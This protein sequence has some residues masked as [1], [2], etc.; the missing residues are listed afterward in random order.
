MN[1][2]SQISIRKALLWDV[3]ST[4][5]DYKKHANFLIVRVFERG[6]VED[7][8][9]IRKYYGDEKVKDAL[10]TAKYIMPHRIH[11]VLAVINEPIENFRCY[12]SGLL[13]RQHYPF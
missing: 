10:L 3:D 6:D 4:T 9:Q 7:I 8:R 2:S 5:L 12:K 13:N 11:L 1:S